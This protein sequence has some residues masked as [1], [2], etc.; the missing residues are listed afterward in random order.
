M[1]PVSRAS[2]MD[3]TPISMAELTY[4]LVC[5]STTLV[6][7]VRSDLQ[8]WLNFSCTCDNAFNTDK[9]ANAVSL[10]ITNGDVF[11]MSRCL[12]VHLAA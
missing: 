11:L 8:Q 9:S 4:R 6:T 12:E 10:H 2:V 5:L 1:V 3:I 7:S